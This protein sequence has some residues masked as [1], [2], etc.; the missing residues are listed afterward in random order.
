MTVKK[1]RIIAAIIAAGIILVLSFVLIIIS[2]ADNYDY[3]NNT[4]I[5]NNI[6]DLDF[7]NDKVVKSNIEDK[8]L[9]NL[10]YSSS[11]TVQV[12]F[13]GANYKLF[14]YKFNS[15]KDVY[16]YGKA[17]SGNDYSEMYEKYGKT[18]WRYFEYYAI[19]VIPIHDKLLVFD[20]T[21]VLYIEGHV[22]QKKFNEFVDYLF[23]NLPQKVDI[24]I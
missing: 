5:F 18:G 9:G 11:R 6:E 3:K 24:L 20:N 1:K 22:S 14:A 8:K 10:N 13:N 2:T 23:A 16:A 21:N 12:E 7:L 4:Y 19:V 17:V 15:R